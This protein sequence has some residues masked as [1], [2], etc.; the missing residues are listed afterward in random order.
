MATNKLLLSALLLLSPALAAQDDVVPAVVTEDSPAF[1]IDKMS[2][3]IGKPAEF[4][5]EM[6][7]EMEMMQMTMKMEGHMLVLDQSHMR[8]A[9]SMDMEA[10]MMPGGSQHIDMLFVGDGENLWMEMRMTPNPMGG[11]EPMIQAMKMPFA[12]IEKMGEEAMSGMGFNM[13]F[14]PTSS[15]LA[16]QASKMFE[17]MFD[18]VEVEVVD[19]NGHLSG[20]VVSSADGLGAQFQMLGINR[21]T[22]VIDG[23]SGYPI[24]TT[25]GNEDGEVMRQSISNLKFFDPKNIEKEFFSYL[26]PEGIQVMD[27]GAMMGLQ[28]AGSDGESTPED[29]F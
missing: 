2:E 6:S 15:D 17:T 27:L 23:K 12:L 22:Y 20:R 1:W 13:G 18:E 11:E 16:A 8:G 21:F 9:L 29:E 3:N 14:D 28:A 24:L 26:P 5:M 10:E 25:M 7:M 19:G 4:D